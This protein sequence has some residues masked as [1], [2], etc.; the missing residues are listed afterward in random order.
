MHSEGKFIF[1]VLR[2]FSV[3]HTFLL[4][5]QAWK[6]LEVKLSLRFENFSEFGLW[7]HLNSP[8]KSVLFTPDWLHHVN[9]YLKNTRGNRLFTESNFCCRNR[10]VWVLR[11]VSARESTLYFLALNSSCEMLCWFE[12]VQFAN[13][14]SIKK[15]RI[16][17]DERFSPSFT[18]AG[19][20]DK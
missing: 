2:A 13:T 5:K 11:T 3:F 14:N 9:Q 12:I 6:A 16:E 1:Q 15:T 18:H 8:R 10:K 4:R 20:S 7:S 17:T 19:R